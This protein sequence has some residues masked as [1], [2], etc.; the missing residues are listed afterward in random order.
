M[1]KADDG[2]YSVWDLQR[3]TFGTYGDNVFGERVPIARV[4]TWPA[5][6]GFGEVQLE[7]GTVRVTGTVTEIKRVR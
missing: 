2:E 3:M 4:I 7:D 5:V 1:V 6:G